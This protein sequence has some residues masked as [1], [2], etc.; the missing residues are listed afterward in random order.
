MKT[1]IKKL[2]YQCSNIFKRQFCNKFKPAFFEDKPLKEYDAEV[3]DLIQKEKKRQFVGLELIASENYASRAV[4]EVT[5]SVLCNKYSEGQVGNRYYGGNQYIDQLETLAKERTLQAF[6]LDPT[7]WGVN[8]QALSGSPANFS[9]YTALLEPGQKILGLHLYSGGH[10]THGFRTNTKKISASSKYFDTDFYY[11]NNETGVIDYDGMEKTAREFKPNIII[12]G[13]SCYNR[14]FDYNRFRKV[15]D[16]VGAYLHVDM[17]HISGLV[18][19]GEHRNP[20]EYADVVMTTTH[21]SLRGPRG[22]LI[23]YNKGKHPEIAE[24]IDF[25][26]FPQIH[27]GPHNYKTAAIAAHMK[28][29]MSPRF[30]E[31]AVQ[32]KKNAKKLEEE[33]RSRGHTLVGETENHLVIWNVKS[34]GLTGKKA[35]KGLDLVHIT[36]NKNTIVGDKSAM[37]PGGIRFGTPA[38]TARGMKENAMTEIAEFVTRYS[39]IGCEV[40]KAYPKL[41]D[42]LKELE[43]NPDIKKL[44]D[45]VSAFSTQ[46]SVPGI[47]EYD[48]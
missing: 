14:D 15:A 28:Q 12:C 25:A 21:K 45:D 35:E 48:F 32:I 9:V 40:G 26:V 2:Q 8:V 27:G 43:T 11:L 23:F 34:W 46:F 42:Y 3:Y 33:M 30:K 20:F 1:S 29:V 38:V 6:N 19:A 47:T 13:G 44:A 41:V 31:Y 10:L 16:E 37:N 4:L 18:A 22:A 17:A 36:T 7:K 24:K 5:G 39:K